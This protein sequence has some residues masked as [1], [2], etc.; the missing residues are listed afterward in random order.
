MAIS[1]SDLVYP[2]DAGLRVVT[3]SEL[4]NVSVP[5]SLNDTGTEVRARLPGSILSAVASPVT[6]TLSG[7][8][9]WTGTAGT[10][11]PGD[12][13]TIRGIMFRISPTLATSN[14][15]AGEVVATIPL[16]DRPPNDLHWRGE[17]GTITPGADHPYKGF[18]DASTGEIRVAAVSTE[19]QVVIFN[20]IFPAT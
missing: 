1:A 19:L 13:F 17:G 3:A 9:A 12:P 15:S 11:K 5:A 6:I 7:G 4:A 16:A 2:H 14:A 10:Y 18:F 8:W 20:H